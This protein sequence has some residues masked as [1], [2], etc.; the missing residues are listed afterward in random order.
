MCSLRMNYKTTQYISANINL[1][2]QDHFLSLHHQSQMQFY[3]KSSR[4][5]YQ[6]WDPHDIHLR[7]SY[8][9]QVVISKGMPQIAVNCRYLLD[10]DESASSPQAHA[11]DRDRQI[12]G[13]TQT[14]RHT[15][16]QRE[17]EKEVGGVR[18]F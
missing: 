5:L 4:G 18:G 14:R 1:P 10:R 9:C 2:S 3:K 7:N 6:Q 12:G 16:R 13:K 8:M 15:Y 11:R 17:G